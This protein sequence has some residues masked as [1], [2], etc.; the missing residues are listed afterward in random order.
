[1]EA[2][3]LD[4][5]EALGAGR[6]LEIVKGYQDEE[7]TR[8]A[9]GGPWRIDNLIAVDWAFKRLA[10]LEAEVTLNEETA[11]ERIREIE[12]RCKRL[13]E[14]ALRGIRFFRGHIQAY[15]ETHKEE[16]LGG[17]QR[18]SRPFLHGTVGW[19]KKAA[20]FEVKD[21]A[22]LLA[23]A[24]TQPLELGLTR[25]EEKPC[26]PEIKAHAKKEGV[27]PPGMQATPEADEIQIR[28]HAETTTIQGGGAF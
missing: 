6:A 15:A 26:L 21:A 9:E 14:R 25:M 2:M 18:K 5:E 19:R 20:G 17:G 3:N 22:A 1:M 7:D 12:R 11:L 28:V 27:V 23:W 16:M 24:Q 8:A 10:A 4:E 13:N